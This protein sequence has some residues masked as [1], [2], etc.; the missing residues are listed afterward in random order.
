MSGSAARA[1]RKVPVRL[2]ASMR[3][4]SSSVVFANGALSAWPALFTRMRDRPK[5][6]ARAAS[7][8]ARTAARRR[9]RRR[10]CVSAARE[11]GGHGTQRIVVAPGQ[12]HRAPLRWRASARSPRRCR[13]PRRSRPHGGRPRRAP[14]DAQ[15]PVGQ[16]QARRRPAPPRRARARDCAR[17]ATLRRPVLLRP[18]RCRDSRSCAASISVQAGLA[19]CGRATAHRSARPATMMLF[20]WSASEI[21]PTAMVAMPASLRMRSAN[22]VWN[23]RPYTGFSCLLT[24]PDEQSIMSAPAALNSRAIST[25]S[26]GVLPPSPSRAPRCAPT[27][28]GAAGHASRTARNT[29]SG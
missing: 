10:Q 19:R 3:C 18:R 21:A 2:T 7:K 11:L 20:T 1:Q 27:S 4:H 14:S 26:S 15:R 9:R 24:W 22:G 8:A 16:R 6:L 12:R 25:A 23:M 13:A 29:S 17:A 28:A 5:R